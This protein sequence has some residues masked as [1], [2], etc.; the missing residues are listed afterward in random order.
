M[1]APHIR[2]AG[3]YVKPVHALSPAASAA[4]ARNSAAIDRLGF[5]S[6][7]LVAQTGA[8]TGAPTAQTLDAK[9]QDSADGATGW[10]D[11]TPPQ[12]SAAIAQITAVDA[13]GRVNVD[14]SGAK[15]YV[16]VVQTIGFT[17]GTSP[18]LE[19]NA[20]F[21]LAGPVGPN[22]LPTT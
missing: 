8:V 18:T 13:T 11:Y 20:A 10:A 22:A 12:G 7:V 4:G 2:N 1:G 17:A 9:V 19:N 16:R 5:E 6:A 15:R 21:V 3:A 14:L